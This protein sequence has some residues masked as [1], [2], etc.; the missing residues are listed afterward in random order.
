MHACLLKGTIDL[1]KISNLSFYQAKNLIR[2]IFLCLS[3]NCEYLAGKTYT[4]PK[5]LNKL[6]L[7]FCI[8]ANFDKNIKSVYLNNASCCK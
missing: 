4:D 6:K 2:K 1:K 5:A 3:K 8:S 7:A